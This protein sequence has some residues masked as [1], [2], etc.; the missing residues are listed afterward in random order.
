MN[1]ILEVQN[2]CR[3]NSILFEFSNLSHIC[4]TERNKILD[5]SKKPTSITNVILG[6][7]DIEDQKLLELKKGLMSQFYQSYTNGCKS[8]FFINLKN[9]QEMTNILLALT[10]SSDFRLKTQSLQLFYEL[11][12][13]INMT[14]INIDDSILLDS[15]NTKMSYLDSLNLSRALKRL[16]ETT[17]KWYTNSDSAEFEA[18]EII[19]AKI[20]DHLLQP[21]SKAAKAVYTEPISIDDDEDHEEGNQIEGPEELSDLEQYF[22]KEIKYVVNPFYQNIFRHLE[23]IES[24]IDLIKTDFNLLQPEKKNDLCMGPAYRTLMSKIY[25]ILAY[26]CIDNQDNKSRVKE[27]MDTIFI[28]HMQ[29]DLYNYGMYCFLYEYITDNNQM[30]KADELGLLIN[31]ILKLL[32]DKTLK[33]NR[34]MVLMVSL[35]QLARYQGIINQSNQ[36]YLMQKVMPT[37]NKNPI[38]DFANS[39]SL[40]IMAATLSEPQQIKVFGKAEIIVMEQTL[41]YYCCFLKYIRRGGEGR[42]NQTEY[43]AQIMLPLKSI[44]CLLEVDHKNLAFTDTLLTFFWKIHVASSKRLPAQQE[45]IVLKILKI[46][47]SNL[48]EYVNESENQQIYDTYIL[49]GTYMERYESFMLKHYGRLIECCYSLMIS[50]KCLKSIDKGSSEETLIEN[51]I[52]GVFKYYQMA[53]DEKFRVI[54]LHFMIHLMQK[55]KPEIAEDAKY[56]NMDDFKDLKRSVMS[57]G[58]RDIKPNTVKLTTKMIKHSFTIKQNNT[59]SSKSMTMT[60]MKHRTRLLEATGGQIPIEAALVEYLRTCKSQFFL[61]KEFENLADKEFQG[62]VEAINTLDSEHKSRSKGKSHRSKKTVSQFFRS[63]IQFLYWEAQ[64]IQE[65]FILIIV[66]IFINFL[67]GNNSERDVEPGIDLDAGDKD[68]WKSQKLFNYR[69]SIL[70]ELDIVR[71]ICK[72]LSINKSMMVNKQAIKLG[73]FVLEGGNTKAQQQFFKYLKEDKTNELFRELHDIIDGSF[74]TIENYMQSKIDIRVYSILQ[75]GEVKYS[76]GSFKGKKQIED[77]KTKEKENDVEE[78]VTNIRESIKIIKQALRFLQLLCEGHYL[79]MQNYL[80]EQKQYESVNLRRDFVST[81]ARML[82]SFIKINNKLSVDLGIQIIEFL[83][84]LIQGPCVENQQKLENCK[85]SEYCKDLLNDISMKKRFQSLWELDTKNSDSVSKLVSK[86][87]TL[88]GALLEGN[89]GKT[90]REQIA[91]NVDFDFLVQFLVSELENFIIRKIKKPRKPSQTI[92]GEELVNIDEF[93][94]NYKSKAKKDYLD[95]KLLESFQTFFFLQTICSGSKIQKIL[96]GLPKREQLAYRFYEE[97]SGCIEV[98]FN[99]YI[100]KY[101]FPIHPAC[102][103]LSSVMKEKF[104]STYN[105]ESPNEKMIQFMRAIPKFIDYMDY[106][107]ARKTSRIPIT[108]KTFGRVRDMLLVVGGIIN[109]VFFIFGEHKIRLTESSLELN[110]HYNDEF[111]LVSGIL[112]LCLTVL[113]FFTWMYV[114]GPI[115]QMDAWRAKLI[116]IKSTIYSHLDNSEEKEICKIILQKNVVDQTFTEKQKLLKY[117]NSACEGNKGTDM[118][119]HLD[120]LFFTTFNIVKNQDCRYFLFLILLSALAYAYSMPFLYTLFMFDVIDKFDTLKNVIKAFSYHKS[121]LI[122][123]LVL[124]AILIYIYS[125]FA[126]YYVGETFYNYGVDPK[127]ENLC[128]GMWHCFTTIFSL[129]DFK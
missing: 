108:Y 27:M 113:T 81:G 21:Q 7:D 86:S 57:K 77:Q 118:L 124:E 12:S 42:N 110:I 38:I 101:Y 125:S 22:C 74:E 128:V 11:H 32:N 114:S 14:K 40:E 25:F 5:N 67:K 43:E 98:V 121:Q 39:K 120:L 24:L 66:Q 17:E 126:Y 96:K 49:I 91:E 80:R 44:L 19:L 26:S 109:G 53:T 3:V 89:H 63:M 72:L 31:P 79:D 16:A 20:E 15:T 64:T 34:K 59:Q 13:Q 127:G 1:A 83:V 123:T 75:E 71:L 78:S 65:K 35:S 56:A 84:E 104:I 29:K 6:K 95:E 111:I 47:A 41:A 8:S 97:N 28:E 70:V 94:Q 92:D 93:I 60:T 54:C 102:S 10:L 99:G 88:L 76:S 45:E 117:Y 73:T 82:G 85:V 37:I 87:I 52:E 68:H 105:R 23:I 48:K 119:S 61:S 33:D 2:D 18:L 58:L 62:L 115:V 106:S 116:D 51:L 46:L 122:S 90:Y 107:I 129:V 50:L 100:Q 55:T 69:Q 112:H 30:L 4:F 9:D 103:H 36:C